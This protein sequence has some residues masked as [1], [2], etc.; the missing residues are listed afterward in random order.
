MTHAQVFDSRSFKHGFEGACRVIQSEAVM[1]IKMTK[2]LEMSLRRIKR[3]TV[4]SGL[5]IGIRG[6]TRAEGHSLDAR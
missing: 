5:G 1:M 4:D 6:A 2:M 3:V